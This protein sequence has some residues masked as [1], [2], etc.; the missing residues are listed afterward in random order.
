MFRHF[1]STA[2]LSSLEL[3]FEIKLLCLVAVRECSFKQS[4]I[5]KAVNESGGFQKIMELI[6]WVRN[7]PAI[8]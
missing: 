5:T 1:S 6:L 8:L 4:P 7:L 3:E 2:G